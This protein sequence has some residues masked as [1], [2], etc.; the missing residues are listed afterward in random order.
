MFDFFFREN[1]TG[2][3]K[4]Y[5]EII[6]S[7]FVSGKPVLATTAAKDMELL[8]TDEVMKEIQHPIMTK[9]ER[10]FIRFIF[11]MFNL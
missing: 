3:A 5:T 9:A 4:N 11:D 1:D 10:M 8:T 7:V 2:I 6:Y